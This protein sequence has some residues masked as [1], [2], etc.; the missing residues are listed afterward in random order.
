[1]IRALPQSTSRLENRVRYR[2]KPQRMNKIGT[3]SGQ[4]V[5]PMALAAIPINRDNGTSA[6]VNSR[7]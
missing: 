2:S 7:I 1:M 6:N 5:K 4:A 3:I